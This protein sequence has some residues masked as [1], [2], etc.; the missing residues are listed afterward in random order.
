LDVGCGGGRTINRLVKMVPTGKIFGIDYSDDSIIVATGINKDFITEG[1][2]EISKASVESLPF[3]NN[4]FNLVTAVETCYFWP[5]LLRN[6]KEILRVLKP[7]G[8]LLIIN[9]SY[10]DGNFDKRNS[11]WAK[12]G[13]FTYHSSN[14]FEVLLTDAGY[15]KIWIDVLPAKSWI[16]AVGVKNGR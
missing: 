2:V 11:K 15:F 12:A 8:S 16:T 1:R 4:F 9:E 13:G 7:G 10:K 14:E 3:P 6:F 5:D